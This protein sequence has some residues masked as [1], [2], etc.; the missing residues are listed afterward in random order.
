MRNDVNT[1]AFC[2]SVNM[3]R[4]LLKMQ[5]IT[6]EEYERIL[7][8]SAAHYDAEKIYVRNENS[9]NLRWMYLNSCGI[10][11]VAARRNYTERNG[12]YDCNRHQPRTSKT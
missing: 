9:G 12:A 6:A 10:V 4:L 11:D 5:F 7:Q 8:I 3:L 1:A 2:Y